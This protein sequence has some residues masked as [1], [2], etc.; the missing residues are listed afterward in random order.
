M[1][2]VPR[3][4]PKRHR[5]ASRSASSHASQISC[6]HDAFIVLSYRAALLT[7]RSLSLSHTHIQLTQSFTNSSLLKCFVGSPLT[8]AEV[9]LLRLALHLLLSG[10]RVSFASSFDK[11]FEISV[12]SSLAHRDDLKG[13][14]RGETPLSSHQKPFHTSRTLH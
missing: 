6:N 4:N 1:F 8:R 9:K 2:L 13:R 3:G 7:G 10:T 12:L 5:V 11:N 14:F